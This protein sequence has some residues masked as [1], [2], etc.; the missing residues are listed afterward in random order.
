MHSQVILIKGL[1]TGNINKRDYL[2]TVLEKE[3]ITGIIIKGLLTSYLNKRSYCSQVILR[4][5]VPWK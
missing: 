2:Q 4:K 1:L 3:A 5:K